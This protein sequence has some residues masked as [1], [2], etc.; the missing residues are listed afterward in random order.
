MALGDCFF[1][2]ILEPI[3][4]RDG[5]KFLA[6][7]SAVE[8]VADIAVLE[9][10]DDQRFTEE[11]DRFEEFTEAVEGVPLFIGKLLSPRKVYVLGKNGWITGKITRVGQGG[12]PS[13]IFLYH[14]APIKSGDS[15]GPIVDDHGRLVGVVSWSSGSGPDSPCAIPVA[16][17]ALPRW[18]TED[19][20]GTVG[21]RMLLWP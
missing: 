2:P 4:T 13:K 14:D 1:E 5:R 6:S 18:L 8:P 9:P 7:V 11:H 12:V 19:Q 17:R 21:K 15:G 16:W 3:Q 20:Y 10:V